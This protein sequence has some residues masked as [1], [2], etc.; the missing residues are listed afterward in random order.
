MNLKQLETF[1]WIHRL[2][3]FNAAAERL[4]ATQ[5]TVSMRIQELE[6]SFGVKLFD[7]SHRT[8]RLTPKGNELLAYAEH[9][10]EITAEMDACITAND[11]MSGRM[12]VGVVELVA[13]SWLPAFIRTLHE[14]HPNIGLDIEVALSFELTER[15]RE[16]ALDLVFAMGRPPG[17]EIIARA[18]GT[19]QLEWMAGS[20]LGLPPGVVSPQALRDVSFITLNRRS[21]H[22]ARVESW[23][24]SNRIRT[25]RL[26]VC[27]SMAVASSLV[28]TGLGISLLPPLWYEREIEAGSMRVVH[29]TDRLTPVEV[30][31]MYASGHTK[32]MAALATEI[33]YGVSTFAKC[34][35]KSMEREAEAV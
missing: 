21:Y 11:A 28:Q 9:L 12:R 30:C 19:M 10:L 23:L 14:R 4:F 26:I 17:T 33:A 32:A 29:T 7:R 25:Q 31:S 35:Q 16:G 5:S 6:Q 8:A 3:S 34:D 18:L 27:N 15:L 13:S 1:Y 20:G 2:G 22:H 24:K